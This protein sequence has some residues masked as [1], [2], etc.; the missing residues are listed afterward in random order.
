M[1]YL[2]HI[3]ICVCT[4]LVTFS[5]SVE[6]KDNAIYPDAFSDIDTFDQGEHTY[7][8]YTEYDGVM[9]D[10]VWN[11]TEENSIY[12]LSPSVGSLHIN[13]KKNSKVFFVRTNPSPLTIPSWYTRYILSSKGS[14]TATDLKDETFNPQK[15]LEISDDEF[16]PVDYDLARNF[17]PPKLPLPVNR[18]AVGEPKDRSDL[19]REYEEG[20]QK[21]FYTDDDKTQEVATL[22]LKGTYCNI[23]VVDGYFTEGVATKTQVNNGSLVYLCNQFDKTYPIVRALFGE[24][25]NFILNKD[26]EKVPVNEKVNIIIYD[27]KKDLSAGGTVGFF[28]GKDFYTSDVFKSSNEGKFFYLDAIWFYDSIGLLAST[29]VHEFQHM[30]SFSTKPGSATW[31]NEML[32]MLCEDALQSHLQLS[33]NRTPRNRLSMF[34]KGYWLP[35]LTNWLG[36]NNVLY[37]YA[38]AYAFGAFLIRNYGGVQLLKEITSTESSNQESINEALRRCNVNKTFEEIFK[39]YVMAVLLWD[40][41]KENIP[42]FNKPVNQTVANYQFNLPGINL[43]NYHIRKENGVEKRGPVLLPAGIESQLDLQPYGF[44]L[45]EVGTVGDD[46]LT[47][48]FSDSYLSEERN[49]IV[50]K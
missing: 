23:W 27:I 29:L 48:N 20:E 8:F 6:I 33:E 31:Y 15:L 39:E 40:I 12:E 4:I 50:V 11:V 10:E 45:H 46:G 13:G 17:V 19:M 18:S 16:V 37:S 22:R 3:F 34:C 49:Y 26:N 7:G 28:W 35:G 9:K 14:R 25:Q 41:D 30:I 32:S 38:S 1:K 2:T 24:E 47:L 21:L 43:G 44:T 36:E 5:C 42:S